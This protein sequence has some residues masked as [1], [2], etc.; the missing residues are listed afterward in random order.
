MKAALAAIFLLLPLSPTPAAAHTGGTT[1]FARIAFQGQSV[2]YTLSLGADTL[3]AAGIG[4]ADRLA[5]I[6]AAKIAVAADGRAC[7]PV[8]GTVTPPT[9][10]RATAVVVVHW[11][12]A[13]PVRTLHLRDD[14]ADAFGADYHT[15][16]AVER[17]DGVEQFVFQPDRREATIVVAGPASGAADASPSGALAFL[18]LGI[19]HILLGFDHVLFVVALLLG[20][21]GLLTLLGVVTAFTVA[22]SITLGLSVLGVV[23]LPPEIVEPVIALSIAYVAAENIMRGRRLSR[24]WTVA[25]LFGLVHGFGFAG[26]LAELELPRAGL[27]LSLVSFNLGVEIGQAAIVALLLP[28]L[29]WLRRFSWQPRAVAAASI[30]LF[31]AGLSLLVDRTLL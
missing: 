14:L 1:G 25:F 27:A 20:G 30:V 18:E 10:D 8:P 16:A 5:A 29:L 11:A 23:T 9:P 7:A 4:D 21:G 26:I 15:L 6:V 2:R 3:Q 24:R 13:A 31:A 17:A 28:L 12:C 19:E 22:H